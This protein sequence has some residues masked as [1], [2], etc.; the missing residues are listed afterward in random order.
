[1]VLSTSQNIFSTVFGNLT[2]LIFLL[3]NI[4][5]N[6][7]TFATVFYLTA[8]YFNA[9]K[10][11]FSEIIYEQ[12]QQVYNNIANLL[13]ATFFIVVQHFLM[14]FVLLEVFNFSP[15]NLLLSLCLSSMS[16]VPLFRP[17]FG[18]LVFVAL[19]FAIGNIRSFLSL[20]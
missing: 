20:G 4:I 8:N 14:T 15:I 18:M 1:M 6:L 10:N 11:F 3:S 2:A 12:H 7:T 16:L 17:W 5:F 9:K 13:Y 19:N